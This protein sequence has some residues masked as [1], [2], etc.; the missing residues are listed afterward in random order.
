MMLARMAL[1]GMEFDY[2]ASYV[3]GFIWPLL[4]PPIERSPYR[5]VAHHHAIV[6]HYE[7]LGGGVIPGAAARA[8]D[9]HDSRPPTPTRSH[10]YCEVFDAQCGAPCPKQCAEC[11]LAESD[12][13]AEDG[14]DTNVE[15][16][17]GR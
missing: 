13:L 4:R 10:F 6:R 17:Y 15:D 16:S 9:H 12:D 14:E 2:P 7:T 8:S 11:A 3:A 1:V 5:F